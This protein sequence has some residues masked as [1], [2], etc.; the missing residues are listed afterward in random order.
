MVFWL[1]IALFFVLIYGAH[2]RYQ[3]QYQLFEFTWNYFIDAVSVPGGFSDWTGRFITQFF[4]SSWAGS[5]I[6]ASIFSLFQLL[7][8]K[9]SENKDSSSFLLSFIPALS[10]FIFF[11]SDEALSGA[12]VALLIPMLAAFLIDRF[13]IGFLRTLSVLFLVPVLYF[14]CGP[15]AVIFVFLVPKNESVIVKSSAALLMVICPFAALFL[16]HF[17][18]AQLFSGIH[19]TRVPYQFPTYLWLTAAAVVLSSYLMHLESS[20]V[21]WIS[22]IASILCCAVLIVFNI[23]MNSE[24]TMK[25]EMLMKDENWEG[26][27]RTARRQV[28]ENA[29]TLSSVNLALGMTDR[30]PDAMFSFHQ[31]GETGLFPT[32]SIS[33]KSL[34]SISEIYWHLGMVN[35]CQQY[36]FDAQEAIPDFQKS[37]RCYQRLAQTNIIN[38]DYKVAEKYLNALSHTLFYRRWAS[39]TLKLL[40]S[41]DEIDSHPVYGKQRSL[42]A[43]DS[44]SLFNE[45]NKYLMCRDLMD[46]NPDNRLAEQYMY[47]MLL[48]ENDMGGFMNLFK[49]ENYKNVP[50][51]YQEALILICVSQ[52]QSMD[53][54][55]GMVSQKNIDRMKSFI[56]DMRS[57]T[58]E[59]TMKKRYGDTFWYY[60]IFKQ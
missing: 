3:E 9:S 35:A 14:L 57:N 18:L 38:G 30:L 10:A 17:P 48:L 46:A 4:I 37:G 33:Y 39:E 12:A 8:F 5:F 54:I 27:L 36:V 20:L 11:L 26:I 41:P 29:V 2:I 28:P 59:G 44:V 15:A 34:L 32:Y 43:S 19:Y 58:P 47:S 53:S 1:S 31:V 21:K 60:S 56:A 22:G 55:S 42:R 51:H 6:L 7:C 45:N 25:Y 50:K 52:H 49:P 24:R 40:E 23:D 13:R 16:F